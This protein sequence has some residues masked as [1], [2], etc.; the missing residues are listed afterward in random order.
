MAAETSALAGRVFRLTFDGGP[1]A[2]KTYEHTFSEDGTVV[3]K[4]VGGKAQAAAGGA[5]PGVK[6]A[7]FEITPQ[8]ILVS[9]LSTHGYTLTVAMN[10]ASK[11]LHGFASNDKNWYPVEGTAEEVRQS[12]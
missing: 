3:F 4:E 11:K 10:R 6:Y 9:Y 5:D 7:A 1:T 8:I 2:G 12:G